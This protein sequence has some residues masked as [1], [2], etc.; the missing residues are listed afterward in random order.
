MAVA[1]ALLLLGPAD[2][3][4][5][6]ASVE[7]VGTAGSA[8]LRVRTVR[9]WDIELPAGKLAPVGK[10]FSFA[11]AL[12]HD[13]AVEL[14]GTALKVD[15]DG[16]GT[17]DI[18][19]EGP[20]ATILLRGTEG[21]HYP[22]RLVD[23]QGWKFAPGGVA[24]GTVHGTPIQLI[25]QNLNGVFGDVGEDA[26]IVGRGVIAAFLS[27]VTAIDG[28][29]YELSIADGGAEIEFRP[30]T[31]ATGT[32]RLGPCE[33]KAKVLSAV[34]RSLDGRHCFDVA[35]TQEGLTVPAGTYQL[36]RGKIGLGENRVDMV[37]G[38]SKQF[39]V[40][41]GGTTQVSWGGPV[42]A[43]F[44]Y[45]HTGG[46]VDLSPD[47][48]WYYGAAGEEYVGWNP[49]GKSP[50]FT[51]RNRKTGREIAQAYFPGTC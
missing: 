32:L 14:E 13:F 8:K 30:F 28:T 29:L 10:G 2:L 34:V 6:D 24:R 11:E 25:D 27:E 16:D 43:E 51:I 20:E 36:F 39:E 44:A 4:A 31:G 40:T 45:R 47:A 1:L 26:I 33:T 23:Q 42:R 41:S 3:P 18:T 49:L 35:S 22:V 17:F 19:A 50:E 15:T 21:R 5:A 37:A 46:Q 48:V 7:G 12:G 38:R 9:D